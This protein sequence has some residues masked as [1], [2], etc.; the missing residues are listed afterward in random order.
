MLLGTLGLNIKTML[1]Y[2]IY[3]AALEHLPDSFRAEGKKSHNGKLERVRML[4]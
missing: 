2:T 3:L 4:G 1:L